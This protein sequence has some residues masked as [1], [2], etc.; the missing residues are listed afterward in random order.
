MF[1][2]KRRN[3]RVLLYGFPVTLTFTSCFGDIHSTLRI[4][5]TVT[6]TVK[7][8]SMAVRNI[9]IA[10]R[11]CQKKKRFDDDFFVPVR[12]VSNTIPVF[13]FVSIPIDNPWF[14]E[15]FTQKAVDQLF[16]DRITSLW[17]TVSV[18]H[19]LSLKAIQ[20]NWL[21]IWMLSQSNKI[22]FKSHTSISIEMSIWWQLQFQ[23]MFVSF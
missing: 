4:V 21:G 16:W 22:F 23:K 8:V 3:V 2:S 19:T 7:N 5:R 11:N 6:G 17:V 10:Q 20:S 1:R 12:L 18:V 14:M 13:C 15:N 9:Q